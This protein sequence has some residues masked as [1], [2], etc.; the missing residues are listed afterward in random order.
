MISP[1]PGTG[2]DLVFCLESRR[3]QE[4]AAEHSTRSTVQP[5]I[6][7]TAMSQKFGRGSALILNRNS[8][9]AQPYHHT[10]ISV[11]TRSTME[12]EH[13]YFSAKVVV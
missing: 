6:W 9:Y 13:M 11:G 4:G 12:A 10:Y 5:S 8:L 1:V 2:C 7:N 3:R